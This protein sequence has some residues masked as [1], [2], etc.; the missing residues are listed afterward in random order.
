MNPLLPYETFRAILGVSPLH[1]WGLGGAAAPVASKCNTLVQE[2]AWQDAQAVGRAEIRAAIATAEARLRDYLGYSVAPHYT[3]DT[4]AWPMAWSPTVQL[5]EGYIE[6]VGVEQL[7]PIDEVAL[8]FS[9][10]DGD[11]L[12]DTFSATLPTD[13]TDPEHLVVFFA[14]TDRFDAMA[15]L[16]RW[17]IAPVSIT[18]ADGE[19]TITGRKWLLVKPAL[20]EMVRQVALDAAN[21]A[22]FVQQLAVYSRH[23]VDPQATLS[24][25]ARPY[26]SCCSTT[27]DPAGV[28]TATARVGIVDARYGIVQPAEAVLTDGVWRAVSWS[29]CVPP[30]RVTVS[31]RAGVPLVGGQ[32]D[33]SWQIVVARLAAA[34]LSAP[35]CACAG[36]NHEL[37]R[38]QT[39]LARTGGNNDEQ[40]G[41][42]TQEQL[43]NPFGSRR[44]HIYAWQRVKHLHDVRGFLP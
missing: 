8:S 41:A 26:P 19:A 33:P 14:E 31:Y 3:S 18:I 24:W 15:P 28:A 43:N 39:D 2:Y 1:A 35:I 21:P 11:G 16:D 23:T 36:A 40:F 22:V 13:E 5:A 37:S 34:E 30:D 32:M 27:T 4:L 7:T 6:A 25:N 44:G 17:R 10:I 20:Y 42:V 12:D 9:D 29:G 38:W